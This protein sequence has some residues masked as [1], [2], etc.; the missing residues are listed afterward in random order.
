MKIFRFKHAL[1][2]FCF[3]CPELNI[4]RA[5]EESNKVLNSFIVA[6]NLDVLRL[7]KRSEL[8]MI[9]PHKSTI[10]GGSG[11]EQQ[12]ISLCQ[13]PTNWHNV[14]VEDEGFCR[15]LTDDLVSSLG[16]N[17]IMM[18]S[19][20]F[21]GSTKLLDHGG[22]SF[23][24]GAFV[25]HSTLSGKYFYFTNLSDAMVPVCDGYPSTIRIGDDI[26]LRAIENS[27]RLE[28]FLWDLS[29]IGLKFDGIDEDPEYLT[30]GFRRYIGREYLE[31]NLDKDLFEKFKMFAWENRPPIE[32]F[33]AKMLSYW[34]KE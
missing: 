9:N 12:N 17:D 2:S 26:N 29:N 8:L 33:Q 24:D 20:Y 27:Q 30:S 25:F 32:E 3:T 7:L 21:Q 18:T 1:S 13:L 22:P 15:Q 31:E 28:D 6:K 34:E 16:E 11:A 10:G 4:L 14:D 5:K 19:S 23:F